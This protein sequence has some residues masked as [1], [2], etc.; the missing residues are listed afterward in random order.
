MLVYWTVPLEFQE[1]TK[2]KAVSTT[3]LST[4]FHSKGVERVYI[5]QPVAVGW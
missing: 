2:L 5:F 3:M 1:L 4:P